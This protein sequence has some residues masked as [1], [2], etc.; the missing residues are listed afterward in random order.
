MFTNDRGPRSRGVAA[1]AARRLEDKGWLV[2]TIARTGASIGARAVIVAGVELGAYCL[3]GAGAVVTRSVLPHSI[4]AGVPARP[5]GWVCACGLPL[6]FS[7]GRASCA[8]CGSG[9]AL[10]G[11]TVRLLGA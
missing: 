3:V 2:P 7:R 5:V 9:Y 10:K 6:R 8:T 11:G 1:T 4:V